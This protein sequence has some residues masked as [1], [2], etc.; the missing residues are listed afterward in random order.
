MPDY[1]EGVLFVGSEGMVIA[2]YGHFKFYPEEKFKGVRRPKV[3]RKPTHVYDWVEACKAGEPTRPGTHF[4]Y[5]GPLT[6]TVLLGTVAFRTG[7]KLT[8]DAKRLEVTNC[9]R[10]N[11]LTHRENRKGWEV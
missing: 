6:E 4:G 11:R 1:P 7:E 3:P 2:D 9:P 10:A 8:W 5:S